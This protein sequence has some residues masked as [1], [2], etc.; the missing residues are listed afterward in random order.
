V[1]HFCA[2]DDNEVLDVACVPDVMDIKS[3][4]LM[5]VRRR[6]IDIES[7]ARLEGRAFCV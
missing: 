5:V 4:P 6:V 3:N 7:N 2:F 1:F